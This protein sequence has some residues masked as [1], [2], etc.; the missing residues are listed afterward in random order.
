MIICIG[1]IRRFGLEWTADA[2]KQELDRFRADFGALRR[3]GDKVIVGL[4]GIVEEPLA[5]L[6]AGGGSESATRLNGAIRENGRMWLPKQ[7][8]RRSSSQ[9]KSPG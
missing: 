8:H 1:E 7:L 6:I 9:L 3:E 5:A 2:I 4:S